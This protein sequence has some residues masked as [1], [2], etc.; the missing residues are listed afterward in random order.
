MSLQLLDIHKHFGPVK[1]S[2][3][4]TLEV[5]A[6]E[7]HGLLGENGAGK[8]TLMKILSGFY[9]ADSGT[10]LLEGKKVQLDSPDAAL[11]SGIGM[12][13]QDPLVFLPLAVVD[14]FLIGSP[15]H[16]QVDRKKARENLLEVCGRFGFDLD[17]DASARDLTIAFSG[18]A[19]A[20]SFSTSRRPASPRCSERS[21]SRHSRRSRKTA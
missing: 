20:S 15:G 17:P 6:G 8:S 19:L 10:V 3:G 11:R 2:D 1:A 12:L 9:R 16:L 13:H 7:L 18:W 4:V 21:S 5:E 14:N